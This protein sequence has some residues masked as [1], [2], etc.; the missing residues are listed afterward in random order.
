MNKNIRKIITG[1]LTVGTVVSMLGMNACTTV[2][3]AV[4]AEDTTTSVTT[5]ASTTTVSETTTEATTSVTETE[6]DPSLGT[7]E[8]TLEPV[9]KTDEI[10]GAGDKKFYVPFSDPE[11][12]YCSINE[13]YGVPL[14]E[15]GWGG[16]YAY[17]AV[18]CMQASYL[19]E[20]GELIDLNPVDLIDRIYEGPDIFTGEEPVQDEEKI[21]ISSGL[22]TDLGGDFDRVNASLCADLLNGCLIKDT[23]YLGT[24][25][26]E[27]PFMTKL[28]LEDV[29]DC[30]REYGAVS[31]SI[32]YK[33]DCKM[34]HGYYTQN[35]KENAEDTD[36]LAT[37][38]GWDDNF[39]KEGFKTPA[40]R[41]G[42]WLVQNS[43]GLYWG[44]CGYYWLSYDMQIPGLISYQVT[45]DYSSA[46]SYGRFC[47][48]YV[49]SSDV[50]KKVGKVMDPSRISVKE[51]NKCNEVVS[52]TVYDVP[53][54]IAAVGIWTTIPDQPYTIEIL[55]GEFG[56]VL[57]TMTGKEKHTGYHTVKLDEP[58]K[59]E[60]YTVVVKLPG[61][62]A[63]EGAAKDIN[64][65]T[66]F[67]KIGARYAVT[68][69]PG[70]SFIKIGEEWVD[71]TTPGIKTLL[72]YDGI[73]FY[74]DFTQPGD[75]CI[76][77]L[78][79]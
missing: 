37:I 69:E 78:F 19:K 24:Y 28:E 73:I 52:A 12:S 61:E 16:C 15:Q 20:H 22:N 31:C 51:M 43:F 45:K 1:M 49:M 62:A 7:P 67:Q 53:G 34:I 38:V 41:N 23:N 3:P 65:G 33:K 36:H 44:N 47:D 9:H 76:T 60:K 13:G 35:Y 63:F 10:F 6:H 50:I 48:C 18:S 66:I 14:R 17:S 58:V 56:E 26:V 25:N 40:S 59:A 54:T 29:K 70:R 57:A 39:P 64:V 30:I 11:H 32:N 75:P 27:Y 77:V 2:E 68:T 42:A 71:V 46:V 79:E 74:D 72:G 21:Y 8:T 5:A 4:S 55:D